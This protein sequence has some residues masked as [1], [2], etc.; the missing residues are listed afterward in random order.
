MQC[1]FCQTELTHVFCDLGHQPPSNSFLTKAQLDEPEMTYPLK[2]MVCDKC[3]LVQLPEIAKA[4][5]IF[6]DDY[7]Y[8]SSQSPANV[9]HAKEYCDMICER[10]HPK[11]VLEIGS[12][13]GY[14]LQWFKKKGCEVYGIDPAA[15]PAQVA[16]E[17][18]IPTC[19]TFFTEQWAGSDR[20]IYRP[21]E[22]EEITFTNGY[23]LIC[24]IN[25]LA[26][27]PDIND[28]VEGMKIALAPK[29]VITCEFPHF[30][31]L[32]A[33]NQF[34]TIYHEHYSYF[35]FGTICEI[36]E[37][38]L[39]SVFDV[40]EIPEHGG[41]LRIY[42]EHSPSCQHSE[43]MRELLLREGAM[44]IFSTAY[45][46]SFQPK[47]DT[48]KT[49]LV[50]FLIEAKMEGKK[51]CAY[52]APAKGNTLLNYCG[53]GP[54]LIRFTCDR[55]PYKQGKYLPGSHIPVYPEAMIGAKKPDYILILAWNLKD[56][57][58]K[59]LSYVREWGCKFIIA[60]PGLK[61]I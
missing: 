5:D 34:D 17:K 15:G 51:I 3:W 56:E 61:V 36:F 45:Y 37:R 54:D 39:L 52:G 29:G 25:T 18:G 42:A 48:I 47:I 31:R 10:F 28:F 16:N 27:Q 21:Y 12:N 19:Q 13:D 22:E 35:S 24:N 40:D 55:S 23:D 4:A 14:M 26:H 6:K 7:V 32:V 9:S 38:H 60:I 50:R 49:H 43:K 30:M 20:T 2:V 59:Q 58:M 46:Q 1:R 33:G 11:T 53:V 57:I 44:G 8:Y 41:S